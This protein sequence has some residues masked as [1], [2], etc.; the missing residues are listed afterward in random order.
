MHCHLCELDVTDLFFPSYDGD[1]DSVP[2]VF[3]SKALVES[4]LPPEG[5]KGGA[6]QHCDAPR[7]A[8]TERILDDIAHADAPHPPQAAE[9]Q[10]RVV[11]CP[12]ALACCREG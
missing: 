3:V 4:R 6:G 9:V 2:T 10:D 12:C 5:R 7:C 1:V 8:L 11:I